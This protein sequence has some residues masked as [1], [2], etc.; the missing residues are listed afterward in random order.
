MRV[1]RLA[2][3]LLLCIVHTMHTVVSLQSVPALD[4]WYQSVGANAV[5]CWALVVLRNVP[6]R[7]RSH[8]QC[9][10]RVPVA[11]LLL[12]VLSP[13]SLGLSEVVEEDLRLDR[14][15]LAGPGLIVL[16]VPSW[17]L[18]QSKGR[19]ERISIQYQ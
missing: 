10:L 7:A 13:R 9:R 4:Q 16:V 11:P 2:E 5:E 6:G 3:Y 8:L 18:I 19:R 1:S 12:R 15:V 17:G 14:S